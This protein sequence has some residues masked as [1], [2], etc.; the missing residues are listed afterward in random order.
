MVLPCRYFT[1]CRFKGDKKGDTKSE[2]RADGAEEDEEDEED[3]SEDGSK[4]SGGDGEGF[5][6][7]VCSPAHR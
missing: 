2:Q 6:A 7:Q 3:T 5:L 4:A 1:W